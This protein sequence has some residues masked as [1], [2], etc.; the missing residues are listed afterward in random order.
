MKYL[1]IDYGTKRIGVAV[2]R[3]WLAEPVGI[4][5]RTEA[6]RKLKALIDEEK[7]DAILLGIPD[8]FI[9]TEA[10]AFAQEL[11]KE[12]GPLSIIEADETLSS[13]STHEKLAHSSMPM[14][15]RRDPIDH[16]AAAAILQDYLDTHKEE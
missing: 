4:F 15:R 9:A 7:P 14:M 11:Q 13:R 2:S 1:A 8:G 5:L 10:R 12:T 16:Y 3:L 6:V